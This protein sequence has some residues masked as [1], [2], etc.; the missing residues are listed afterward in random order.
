VIWTR[1]RTPRLGERV[2]KL[3]VTVLLATLGLA[4]CAGHAT[5]GSATAAVGRVAPD[6]TQPT[7]SGGRLSMNSLVG[8]PVYLNFFATWCPP[9]N[10]EAPD[11]N[12]LQKQFAGRGL[13]VVGVDELENAKKAAQF[14]KKFDL[15]Y[16]AVVDD[17]TLQSQ[18]NVNGLPVHVF[19][20]RKGIVRKI[21]TGEM[22]KREIAA[23]I[24][25]IL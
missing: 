15:T 7:S 5:S 25:S 8:K 19:I 22:S 20:D 18:Y 1:W 14:V 24:Q 16:P 9:C 6:W 10:E 12:A 4:A 13:T 3:R 11:I 2:I 17:G 21:V 23:A